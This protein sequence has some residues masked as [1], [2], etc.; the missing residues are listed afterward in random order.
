MTLW[1]QPGVPHKGW[2]CIDVEDLGAAD[3]TCEMCGNH[4]LRYIHTMEHDD[5]DP[6][7][8]GCVCA[9]KMATD[10]D[11]KAAETKLKNKAG[12]RSRWLGRQ[13]RTSRKGNPYLR[14]DGLVIG[15]SPS[16]G[17]RWRYWITKQGGTDLYENSPTS[18]ETED[19]AKLALFEPYWQ[20]KQ[21]ASTL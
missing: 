12:V 17:G 11:A 16:F 8:V 21:D 5:H 18:Y 2:R 19:Q 4:P 15:V 7:R 6:L 3:D 14:I 10:Y 9:E 20:A 1:N 13:W